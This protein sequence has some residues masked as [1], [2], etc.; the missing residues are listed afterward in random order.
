MKLL[1]SICSIVFFFL[2]AVN[3][4]G[5]IITRIA[6]N[7]T[8]GF[9]GDGGQATAAQLNSPWQAR[10][11]YGGNLYMVDNGNSR[12]RKVT[13]TG[14]IA[15]VAGNGMGV[16]SGD[17]GQATAAGISYPAAVTTDGL[18]NI[19]IAEDSIT[20]GVAWI[21]KITPSGIIST[22]AGTGS[23][24][25]GGDGGPAT[26]AVF[27]EVR[28][29]VSDSTGNLY[30][31]DAG[32]FRVRKISSA[33]TVSTIAGNGLVGSSGDGGPATAAS[34]M[35]PTG[36]AIDGSGYLYITDGPKVRGISTTGM[37]TTIAG[38]G[39]VGF[40]G[41]GG[42]ATAAK[43][44]N[45]AGIAVDHMGAIYLADVNNTRIRKFTIGGNISTIAGNGTPGF[46]G[47]GGPATAAECDAPQGVSVDGY[48]RVY[49]AD[50]WANNV[51][52]I[53][54]PTLEIKTQTMA[55][56]ETLSVWPNPNSGDFSF[57]VAYRFNRPC[58]VVIT[59]AVGQTIREISAVT[60]Q[61]GRVVL[62]VSPGLYF[63]SCIMDEGVQIT[64][65]VVR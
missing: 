13:A 16:H 61:T 30:I 49:I 3:A 57:S 4:D 24:G 6:G 47:D 2:L 44:S 32:N 65:V 58:V 41:D 8:A 34:F 12:I 27:T 37:I 35:Q 60:N 62:D 64:K 1:Q 22:I 5:Q 55:Q 39:T 43:L 15:T 50:A 56:N 54:D 11:G 42:P 48:G 51:R 36:I 63:L 9:S 10:P 59:N 45:P 33:G 19:Y 23:A 18:G 20:N 46:T 38:T 53:G 52:M 28:D 17:G 29:M 14:V 31:V 7:D 40:S 25:F 21:R 26:A